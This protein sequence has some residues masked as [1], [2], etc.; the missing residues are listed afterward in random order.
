LVLR[1]SG[2]QIQVSPPSQEVAASEFPVSRFTHQ[3]SLNILQNDVCHLLYPSGLVSRVCSAHFS[4]H[5]ILTRGLPRFWASLPT[6][7][8][9]LPSSHP[10]R[11]WTLTSTVSLVWIHAVLELCEVMLRYSVKYKRSVSDKEDYKQKEG[12]KIE[13]TCCEGWN[14][15][16]CCLCCW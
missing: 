12:E 15:H 5:S 7:S 6:S 2:V 16:A 11:H 13:L 8:R 1:L 9:P 10:T 3:H 4:L 14:A